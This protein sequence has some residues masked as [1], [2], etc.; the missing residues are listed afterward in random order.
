MANVFSQSYFSDVSKIYFNSYHELISPV[1]SP[2]G[3][4]QF[5]PSCS[6][7][8]REAINEYGFFAG[9]TMTGDRLIRC[10]GGKADPSFYPVSNNKLLDPASKNYIIGDGNLWALGLSQSTNPQ[11]DIIIKSDSVLGYSKFLFSKKEF[12]LS[13]SEL[14][15]QQYNCNDSEFCKYL[16]VLIA[17]NYTCLNNF[18]KAMNSYDYENT[19]KNKNKNWNTFFIT[20]LINDFQ[21]ANLWNIEYC[22][23]NL[24]VSIE[25]KRIIKKLMLYSMIKDNNFEE[26][27]DLADEVFNY[28]TA[29]DSIELIKKMIMD[30]SDYRTKSPFMAGLLSTVLPGTGYMYCGYYKEG[31]SS[32]IVNGLF[33]LGI[34]S[35]FRNN[36][37]PSG[38]LLSAIAF[39]FYLGNIVG[40]ANCAESINDKNKELNLLKIRKSFEI[41][42]LFSVENLLSFWD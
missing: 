30:C 13:I 25:E 33:G 29:K 7:Y 5:E 42:Y 18:N 39:P 24:P 10:S 9:I 20:Y 11:N 37:T 17:V 27:I 41:N 8:S 34:Y 14:Y 19:F 26:P 40:S 22:K 4:C 1:K 31:I 32:L 15:K 21:D 2:I 12:L 6:E 38:I 16:D 36:N 23:R 3:H 35:L 28:K